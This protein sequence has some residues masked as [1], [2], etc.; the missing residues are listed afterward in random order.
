[1]SYVETAYSPASFIQFLSMIQT[2][3]LLPSHN[4]GETQNSVSSSVFLQGE[5]TFLNYIL[6]STRWEIASETE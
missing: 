2:I 1:M 6:H 4:S 3:V 5:K